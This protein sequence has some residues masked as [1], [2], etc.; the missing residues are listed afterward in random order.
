[1]LTT[2]FNINIA[3]EVWQEESY[4]DGF[5]AGL[6]E[7]LDDGLESGLEDG[8]KEAYVEVFIKYQKLI[9]KKDVELRKLRKQLA[10]SS[11]GW[12]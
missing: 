8:R 5:E 11:E 6:K 9:A 4:E 10:A 1:M 12:G 7:G 3:K 2:E